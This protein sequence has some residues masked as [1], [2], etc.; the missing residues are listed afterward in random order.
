M[1]G[2]FGDMMG[3]LQEMKQKADEI[4]KRL[5]DITIQS[6]SVGGNIRILITGSRK[7]KSI[8]ISEALK[9]GNKKELE[10]HLMNAVNKAIESADKANEDEM[11]KAASGLLPG[12]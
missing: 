9:Q 6:E 3:K 1:F 5:E 4:K 10:E 8:E 11:K 12:L 2:K 7:I